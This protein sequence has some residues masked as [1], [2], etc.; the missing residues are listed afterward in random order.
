MALYNDNAYNKNKDD[1]YTY[2]LVCGKS[3]HKMMA[4]TAGE[5]QYHPL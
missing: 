4:M 3:P 2:S 1:T 5:K